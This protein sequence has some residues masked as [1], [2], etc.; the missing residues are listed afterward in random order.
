MCTQFQSENFKVRDNLGD[1]YVNGRLILKQILQKWCVVLTEL[2]LDMV[3]CRTS[4]N[5]VLHFQ[6]ISSG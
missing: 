3:K 1:L 5:T 6:W 4:A 2:A